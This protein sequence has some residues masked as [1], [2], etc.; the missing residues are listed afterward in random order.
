MGASLDELDKMLQCHDIDTK[1]VFGSD[2]NLEGV[3]ALIYYVLKQYFFILWIDPFF[4]LF[5]LE[6]EFRSLLTK[7]LSEPD[8]TYVLANFHRTEVHQEGGGHFSPV[9]A[10]DPVQDMVLIAGI[11]SCSWNGL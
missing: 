2:I 7:L 8:N 4:Y 3:L 5:C 6:I 1:I 9:V 10:L 11:I